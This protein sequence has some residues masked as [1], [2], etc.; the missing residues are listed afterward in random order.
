MQTLNLSKVPV[1]SIGIASIVKQMIIGIDPAASVFLFGSRARGD[2]EI[3][4]DWDFLILTHI[5]DTEAI[6]DKLRK[7]MLREV[8]LKYDVG[9]SL[10]VKNIEIWETDYAVSNIYDSIQ[11]EGILL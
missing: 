10:L 7:K 5:S 3:Y 8:E 2:A 1:E 11:E 6:S 4:S 9:I